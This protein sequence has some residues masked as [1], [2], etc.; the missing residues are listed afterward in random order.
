MYMY[1]ILHTHTQIKNRQY[2]QRICCPR[3]LCC[4]SVRKQTRGAH[5]ERGLDADLEGNVMHSV[6]IIA[7]WTVEL[8]RGVP[9][10]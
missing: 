6:A 5:W 2:Q 7:R 9:L 4:F 1:D 3:V 8:L 10:N